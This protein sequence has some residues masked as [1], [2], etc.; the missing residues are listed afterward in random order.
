MFLEEDSGF[1]VAQEVYVRMFESKH[2]SRSSSSSTL[3]SF[4]SSSTARHRFRRQVIKLSKQKQ[5]MDMLK[6]EISQ[7]KYPAKHVVAGHILK[8]SF[9]TARLRHLLNLSDIHDPGNGILMYVSIEHHFDLGNIC[10]MKVNLDDD[11]YTVKILWKDLEHLSIIEEG[12]RILGSVGSSQVYEQTSVK[13]F[14]D[15][16]SI[17]VRLDGRYKRLICFHM[18]MTMN[19]HNI[20]DVDFNTESS[21]NLINTINFWSPEQGKMNYVDKVERWFNLNDKQIQVSQSLFFCFKYIDILL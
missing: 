20:I 8:K 17:D 4:E 15:L 11:H 19:Q 12:E 1:I 21:E 16:E 3:N 18:H 6:C 13:T 14:K 5:N 7:C 9:G 10:L 2:T